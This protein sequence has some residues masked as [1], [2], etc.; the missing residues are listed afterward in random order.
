MD[1]R[2]FPHVI[3]IAVKYGLKHLT[4]L[5][6]DVDI[7]DAP[8]WIPAAEALLNPENTAYFE[9]LES[10]VVSAAR[11]IVNTIRASD[12]RRE[13]FQQIIKELNQTRENANK[14]PGL[15]LLRD[16]DTRWSSIFLMIDRLLLLSEELTHIQC[17]VLNDI[18]EFLSYPHAVQEE[19]SGEQTPTLSQVLPLYE[20]LITNLTHA[21]EDLPKISHAID[22]T[23][24]K[25]K[26]YVVRSR[27][28]PVYILA[29]GVYWFDLH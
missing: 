5:P 13:T 15:Q 22:A 23:I 26:E 7:R 28:N 19:L 18:R 16:V 14:I 2:C 17:D 27:K 4:K 25:L 21:K 29:M 12:Q 24:E 8:G 9:C 10:D 1:V 20:Q 11:K 3:N 6:D